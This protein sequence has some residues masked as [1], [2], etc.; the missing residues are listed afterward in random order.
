MRAISHLS[1]RETSIYNTVDNI[2]IS[3]SLLIATWVLFR[4]PIRCLA[5]RS[6][7]VSKSQDLYCSIAMKFDMRLGRTAAEVHVKFESNVIIQT[8]NHVASIFH[9]I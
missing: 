8:T 5:V 9:E 2:A 4:Y 6:H 7:E 1:Q 3:A